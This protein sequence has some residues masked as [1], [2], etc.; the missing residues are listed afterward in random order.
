MPP[1]VPQPLAGLCSYHE[2]A[3]TGITV[4]DTVNR[5]RRYVYVKTQLLFLFASRFNGVP[6][7]E[8]KGAFSLHLWQDAEHST[9]FRTRIM[10]MRTPPHQLERAPDPALQSFVEQLAGARDSLELLVAV[11]EV[12]KPAIAA[13]F[14]SH[15][16]DSHPVAD[17]PTRR[18][19]R[20]ALAEEEEQIAW[21]AAAIAA[22]REREPRAASD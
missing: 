5:L 1:S 3:R 9:W 11:Y 12:A 7:W 21:G 22:M 18:L 10:E 19:L 16:E 13:A 2:A 14:R 17:Q 6:E 20:F 4:D 8:T 15:L